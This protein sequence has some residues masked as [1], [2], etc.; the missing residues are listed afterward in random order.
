MSHLEITEVVLV[1]LDIANNDYQQDSI[2]LYI[3]VPNKS[4]GQLLDIQ[5]PNKFFSK[6]FQN[7]LMLNYGLLIK[8]LHHQGKKIK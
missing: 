1:N 3:F 2:V 4:L 7:F 8:I 5:P 6:S